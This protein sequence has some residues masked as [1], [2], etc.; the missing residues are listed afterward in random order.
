MMQVVTRAEW[1]ARPPKWREAISISKGV[2]IH[3]NGGSNLPAPVV[4]GD[5]DAVCAHLRG[6]QSYHM[7]TQG[8]PD[9]AYSFCV[10]SVGRIYELRGFA[11]A[12]AHTLGWNWDSHAIYLPLGGDQAPTDVQIAAA[13]QVIAEHDR[14]F[15][16]GFVKGHQQAPN[17]TSCPGGPTMARIL[18]GDFHATDPMPPPPPPDP[19]EDDVKPVIVVD[20]RPGKSA[21]HVFGNTRY[22]LASQAEIDTLAYMGTEIVTGDPSNPDPIVNWLRACKDL[23]RPTDR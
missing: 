13:N 19:D 4:G 15:G 3:Y 6:V 10:D 2:F 9:I 20:P 5:F 11:V 14:R 17:S 7:N 12:G 23:G 8:W 21:W 18:A 22:R 1:G 16:A